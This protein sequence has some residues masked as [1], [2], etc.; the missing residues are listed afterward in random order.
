MSQITIYAARKILTMNPRRPTATHLAVRDGRVLGTGNLDD[1]TGWGAYTLDDRFA[2]KVLMPGLVEGHSHSWE[3]SAWE[4]TYV[5]FY[6]RMA[7]DRVVHAGLKSIDDV[8]E[9]LRQ[10]EKT[11]EDPNEPLLAWGFD[12]IFLGDRR[13]NVGDLNRV[14]STRCILVMHQSG[15]IINVNSALL[16]KAGIRGDSNAMGLA[17]DEHGNPSGEL[18]G[19]ALRNIAY[20]AV[21]RNRF[22]DMGRGPSLWRFAH[23]AL[24]AGVT[25]ATDLANE[26]PEETVA[27]QVA[28]TSDEAFPLRLVPAFVGMS[29]PA[30]E[31]VEWVR[32]LIPRSNERLRYGLVKLV[33]DGSIQ[34]FTARL[35]WPGYYNGNPNGLWYIDPDEL[36]RILGTYHQSGLQVHIH[37]NGDQASAAA[38]DAI[39]QVLKA[40]PSPD[41]R[42]T[43]QHCQMAH[44]AH[45]RRMRKLGIC[46]NLFA[47]H[48]YYWGE[49]H[50]ALTMGPE[51]A[52]RMDA[53]GTAERLGVSYAIHSDAPVTHLG[54][55]FTAW[56]AVNRRTS[57][58]RVLGRSECISVA[59]ALHAITIGAA[60]TLKLDHEIG[61]LETGKRAD[62][63]ILDDDPTAVDPAALKDVPIWGTMVGGRVFACEDLG[64]APESG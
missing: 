64:Q 32:S 29:R 52:E 17:R 59:Q 41:A 10:V 42:F 28:T 37:T 46:A 31:G 61:S 9:R 39:E 6:D 12:P 44:D 11:L 48:L 58:G 47:N 56:C 14:S 19:P 33:L 34:G 36:P 38:I 13:M 25:T 35:E 53:A 50:R 3:G 1:L 27:S 51:R 55:L 15:H 26:L 62:V 5:G 7:P 30:D 21:G 57:A 16:D 24:L 60:Y 45:F 2:D 49:Q 43:L 40:H 4:D 63:A 8:V 20:R 54:P 23:S 18:Q 22:L